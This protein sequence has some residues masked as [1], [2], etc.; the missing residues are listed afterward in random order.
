MH[1]MPVTV[2]SYEGGGFSETEE[3]RRR[4]A[5]EHSHIVRKYMSIG[6][7]I[8]YRLL[9]LFTLAPLRT[10]LASNEKTA[11]AYQYVKR[12]LYGKGRA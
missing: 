5:A 8:T 6:Q 1:Y 7:I 9:L 2:V 3:N 4:S 11:A 12:K 10:Y